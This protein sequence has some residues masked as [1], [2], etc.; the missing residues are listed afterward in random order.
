MQYYKHALHQLLS[1]VFLLTLF[2]V[3]A[4][5]QDFNQVISEKL[6]KYRSVFPA[7]KA[8]L[9]TDKPYYA[10]GDT[11]W[12]KAYLV[13]GSLHKPDSASTVLYV[14]LIEQ[15][16]GK[17]V[18]LKRV[19]LNGGLGH[20]SITLSDT[21]NSGAYTV[22]AY[23]NWMRNFSEDFFFTKPIYLF[24]ESQP[25]SPAPANALDVKFFPESGQL[26]GGHNTRIALKAIN[27]AGLG[28]DVS[29]FV[30]DQKKDTVASIKSEHLGMGR[31][32]FSPKPG[33]T[34]VAFLRSKES[35]FTR[36]DFPKVQEKGYT[37]VVD[38]ISNANR[39]RVIVYSKSDDAGE[40][41]VYIVGHSRGIIAFAAKGKVSSKGLMMNIPTN[42]LPDG[43]THVTLFDEQNKPLGER[44]VF[45]NHDKNLKVKIT[46]AKT[47]YKPRE[48][49][50]V[51]IMV[52][53]SIGKPVEANL[54]VA[55]T[56]GAQIADQPAEMNMVSFLTLSS[57]LKGFVEKPAYY[58][59]DANSERKI[60]MDFLMMTQGWS[61]FRWQDVLA[62]SLSGPERFVEQ[63]FTIAG[64]VKRGSR[65]VTDKLMLSVF[66]SNDSL[67]T[68]MTAETNETGI[69]SLYNLVF[70]DSLQ[71]RLQG[72]NKKNNQNLTFSLFPF[73]APKASPVRVPF[74]PTTVSPDQ[75]A[76]YLKRAEEYQ[77]IERK[78]RESREKLLNVV[79]IKAKK[80]VVRDSRK[81]YSNADASLKI[82]PQMA[83]G[84]QSVLDILGGRVAGVRVMGQG[85][86]AS[87]S[88]RNGG[89]PLFVLDGITVDKAMIANM[90]VN[91]VETIDVLKGG[92]AAI[93][94]SRGGNG[95]ISVLTKRGNA[96][97]DY[98]QEVVPGTLVAKIAGFDIPREFYAPAYD[99]K[100][101]EDARPDYRSTIYWAPELKTGKDGK[102]RIQYYNTDPVTT[103]RIQAE[104]LSPAGE[105][106]S[107][108]SV[109]SVQ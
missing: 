11:L 96:N 23:T 57:D 103:V 83:A 74:F 56:D 52:T 65:K 44:L 41:S 12:F 16:T 42:E 99:V 17:N 13:E 51:E 37:M 47:A 59:D 68:F 29:G 48:K 76:A 28:T 80:E 40:K 87:V 108:K 26:V 6:H 75:L 100:R 46:P 79:T 77:E 50:E 71:L 90:N 49:T 95:V 81:L 107:G 97:Y 62:D 55:V 43:I 53:D 27:G 104:V 7:E 4:K 70:A 45:I 2:S 30:L 67:R 58:F 98:T 35:G 66:L 60:H 15:K 1:F 34:Y 105:P 61:R 36:F 54:S 22:R 69:F 82:T 64:E 10:N 93:Y 102:V 92:S 101:Q 8:Y 9:H 33:D 32:Q 24:D 91:D 78:I 109:Y 39:M 18:A 84:A 25:F 21:I 89:E 72:M 38:N 31:F 94:G 19:P 3:S 14:D 5:G 88:I 86:N 85:M 63:G 73:E 20:G 106:G